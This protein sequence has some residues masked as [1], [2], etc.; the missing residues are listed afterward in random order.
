MSCCEYSQPTRRTTRLSQLLVSTSG[1]SDAA[2]ATTT[3][4]TTATSSSLATQEE[5]LPIPSPRGSRKGK[6]RV[7]KDPAKAIA[8]YKVDVISDQ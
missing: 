5:S 8:S 1:S 6:A 7:S 2:G 4:N 3:S